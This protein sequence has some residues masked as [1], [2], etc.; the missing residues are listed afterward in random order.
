MR[1]GQQEIA[2]IEDVSFFVVW[3]ETAV[4]EKMKCPGGQEN[5]LTECG[6]KDR[7]DFAPEERKVF[8]VL[9]DFGSAFGFGENLRVEVAPSVI[10][11]VDA[12]E[13]SVREFRGRYGSKRALRLLI[14]SAGS[15]RAGRSNR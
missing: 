5:A 4:G 8:F 11:Q 14:L 12:G 3:H 6:S 2:A 1:A 13:N 15:L 7:S 10:L 9:L